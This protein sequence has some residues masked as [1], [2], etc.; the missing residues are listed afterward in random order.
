ME[1]SESHMEATASHTEDAASYIASVQH[2]WRLHLST[3]RLQQIKKRMFI[4]NRVYNIMH[5]GC[6]IPNNP[7]ESCTEAE[8]S[9]MDHST[10]YIVSA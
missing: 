2:A 10:T 9:N 5:I 7:C 1:D 8:A 6:D 4:K 3:K